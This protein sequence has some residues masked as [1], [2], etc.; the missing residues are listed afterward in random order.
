ME[1]VDVADDLSSPPEDLNV[2]LMSSVGE[3]REEPGSGGLLDAVQMYLEVGDDLP[4]PSG[5]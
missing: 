5:A 4:I 3:E 1:V 2:L